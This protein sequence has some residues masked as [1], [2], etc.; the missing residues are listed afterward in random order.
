MQKL[1]GIWRD[2]MLVK[3]KVDSNTIPLS[4]FPQE[5]IGNVALAMA[6]SL[7][8]VG[9]DWKEIEIKLVRD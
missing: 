8:G 1:F 7:R 2:K 9:E 5:I 4:A 3:L 6:E